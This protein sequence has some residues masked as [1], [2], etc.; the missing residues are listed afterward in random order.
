MARPFLQVLPQPNFVPE[1]LTQVEFA[2]LLFCAIY[3]LIYAT[4]GWAI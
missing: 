3:E 2:R 1:L 4:G